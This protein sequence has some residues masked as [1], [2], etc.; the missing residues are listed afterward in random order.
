MKKLDR[1]NYIKEL[2]KKLG[3]GQRELANLIGLGKDGERTIRGWEAGEH[4]PSP[5]KWGKIVDLEKKMQDFHDNSPLKQGE[6]GNPDFRFIDL[7]A[8]IGGIRYPFQQLGGHCVFTSEWDKFAQRTYLAN[9]GEM[10]NGDIT[11]IEAKDIP[12]HEILLGG[13]PCQ[14]FS[15]AGLG[16]G[17]SDTRGTMFFEVQRILTEKKP[18]A[19]LLENVKQLRGHDKGRTLK[20]IMDILQGKHDQKIPKDIPMS[21][22]ARNALAEKLNYWVDVRVL[23]ARDFGAPQNRER[24][25]II[26]FDKD[27]YPDVDFDKAFCWPEPPK[28]PTRVGNILQ[29]EIKL[30]ADQKEHGKDR[31]TISDRLWAGH[32]KRK[33]G[34]KEKGNGFGYS[35]FNA[36][37]VYTNTI[38]ARYYKDGSEILLDQKHLNKNPRKL[39]PRECARLQGFPETFKVNAVSQNQAYQQFGNSVC[40]NV[41]TAIAKQ[42]VKTLN[43]IGQVQPDTCFREFS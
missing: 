21:G 22:E 28:T 35:L 20:M 6:I 4:I 27:Q 31:F 2:R 42:M 26:G 14:A 12:D 16:Q 33:A 41:I 17:F 15:Q 36:D 37:S 11:K 1:S 24:V 9:Y 18:K 40:I 19:F 43:G 29:T 3:L 23:R 34:H 30:E 10:P 13:F 8:G 25:F 39:T 5:L 38:S 32:Q 7:F